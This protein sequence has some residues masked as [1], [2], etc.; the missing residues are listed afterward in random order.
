MGTAR[1]LQEYCKPFALEQLTLDFD[2]VCQVAISVAKRLLGARVDEFQR[3][4][5]QAISDIKENVEDP[6]PDDN[7][8]G[9]TQPAQM[10]FSQLPGQP[11]PQVDQQGPSFKTIREEF[12]RKLETNIDELQ[13]YD[14]E[15]DLNLDSFNKRYRKVQ[16]F[17]GLIEEVNLKE[18]LCFKRALI[19][20]RG[21]LKQCRLADVNDHDVITICETLIAPAIDG[22][23]HENLLLAIECIGLLTILDKQ[24]FM[25]YSEIF[26]QILTEDVSIENKREKVIAIKSVV[27]GLI[28]HGLCDDKSQ[29]LFDLIT[30]PFLTIREKVLRQVSIEGVCKMLF[31][32]KLCDE[33]DQ[34]H[35]ESILAQLV[36]Q[37]FDKKFNFQ[38][39][40][41]RSILT[42]F[43]RNFVLFSQQRCSLMLN[44]VTKVVYAIVRSKYGLGTNVQPKK[45]RAG[46]LPEKGN[47]KAGKGRSY[48]SGSESEFDEGDDFYSSDDSECQAKKV[49][50][51][52]I[53]KHLDGPLILQ[54]CLPLLQ[55]SYI[56]PRDV[57]EQHAVFRLKQELTVVF[58]VRLL[59][60]NVD[61][62][63]KTQVVKDV[64]Q[65]VLESVGLEHC[66]SLEQLRVLQELWGQNSNMLIQKGKRV[67]EF[68]GRLNKRMLELEDLQDEEVPLQDV[69]ME[70]EK[71]P[72]W[73]DEY[74]YGQ[75]EDYWQA[76]IEDAVVDKA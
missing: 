8:F 4:M 57:A 18:K 28:V 47:K 68:D 21:L 54:R 34:D 5:V 60:L 12:M 22:T 53:S 52:E 55:R 32:T 40:L 51:T 24:V 31:S 15:E 41:V 10:V 64:I 65:P 20:C 9:A 3:D 14:E 45:A 50:M 7:A 75:L 66:D 23:D 56:N 19:M 42:V 1:S 71:A 30:G 25:N 74:E 63:K 62:F 26:R 11:Q 36:Y 70:E 44:A 35:V 67:S 17:V 6:A 37:L 13:G 43:F 16:K 33:N 48:G 46:K 38:N 39:S 2:D 73:R 69:V 59:K 76:Y 61:T 72:A 27:D 58:M 29:A 49:K